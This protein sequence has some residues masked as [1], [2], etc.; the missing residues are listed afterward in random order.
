[1]SSHVKGRSLAL[2]RLQSALKF[3][4][5]DASVEAEE[6]LRV[7]RA[8]GDIIGLV[9]GETLAEVAPGIVGPRMALKGKVPTVEWIEVVEADRKFDTEPFSE[10]AEHRSMLLGHEE[11]ERDFLQ[12]VTAL[13][14]QPVFR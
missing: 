11:I 6:N 12:T 5:L 1:K 8:I 9:L 10:P 13:E 2:A 4:T 3:V 14:D 7:R